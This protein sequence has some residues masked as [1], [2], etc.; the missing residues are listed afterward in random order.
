MDIVDIYIRF[1]DFYTRVKPIVIAISQ[2]CNTYGSLRR[3]PLHQCEPY[4]EYLYFIF[5]DNISLYKNI[6]LIIKDLYNTNYS[7]VSKYEI[8]YMFIFFN[9]IIILLHYFGYN[10]EL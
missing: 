3:V 8:T 2:L 7:A 5:S 4:E 1:S 10:F 6:Q 9:S